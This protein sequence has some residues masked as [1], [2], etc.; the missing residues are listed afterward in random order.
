MEFAIMT[1]ITVMTLA[2]IMQLVFLQ[3]AKRITQYAAFSAA[4]SAI[5]SLPGDRQENMKLSAAVPLAAIS[6]TMATEMDDLNGIFAGSMPDLSLGS[7]SQ[8]WNSFSLGSFDAEV[9]QD[10]NSRLPVAYYRTF[11]LSA[12]PAIDGSENYTVTLCYLYKFRF[13]L[14]RFMSLVG[15]EYDFDLGE[16]LIETFDQVGIGIPSEA[17]D[18]INELQQ[19]YL[20]IV[21]SAT[22]ANYGRTN[23]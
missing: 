20:P 6:S 5:V 23:L 12:G 19:Y 15:Q 18:L 17:T 16:Q 7:I 1:P 9:S 4:R 13:P 10:L 22:V 8:Y 2:L 21:A 3:N 14:Q 11:I